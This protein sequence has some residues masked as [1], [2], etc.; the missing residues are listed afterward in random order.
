M[1]DNPEEFRPDLAGQVALITGGSRGIGRAIAEA[2]ATCGAAVAIAARSVEQVT[3]TIDAI[4]AAGGR[5]VGITADVSDRQAVAGMIQQVERDLGPI[6]LLINNAATVTPLGPIVE[7]DPDEWWRS[8]EINIRGPLLCARMVLPTMCARGRGRIVNM[9]SMAAIMPIPYM[10]A[11]FHSKIALVRLTELLALETQAQGVRVF[12]VSPG[13]VR[14]EMVSP[15][16]DSAEG[17]QWTPWVREQFDK[18]ETPV[19]RV[20]SLMLTI[21]TGPADSLTGRLINAREDFQR[22]IERAAEVERQGLYS[23]RIQTLEGLPSPVWAV[24]G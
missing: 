2:L 15:M 23:L 13:T 12:S 19:H 22:V 21:A 11:Y 17:R 3:E 9:V 8:Q 5:A 16:M 4:A 7:I 14:T 6:D 24:E 1:S 18:A 20:V 10:S